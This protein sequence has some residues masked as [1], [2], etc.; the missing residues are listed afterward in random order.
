MIQNV[1]CYH[2]LHISKSTHYQSYHCISLFRLQTKTVI[3]MADKT[4]SLYSLFSVK[5]KCI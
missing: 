2:Q 5:V 1:F 4:Y 3:V